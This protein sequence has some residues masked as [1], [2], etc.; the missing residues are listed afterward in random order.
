M[1]FGTDPRQGYTRKGILVH[2]GLAF[3][4]P[5]PPG[6]R[7]DNRPDRVT[8]TPKDAT[9]QAMLLMIS[10]KPMSPEAAADTFIHKSHVTV[11]SNEATEIHG[12][13]ARIVRSR[14]VAASSKAA[15]WRSPCSRPSSAKAAS[16]SSSTGT[17]RRTRSTR[18]PTRFGR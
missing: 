6:W 8:L 10:S 17:R 12:L 16:S 1:I 13:P 7:V 15:M 5:V 2:P 9:R 18:W 4:F 3:Q 11:D 14:V